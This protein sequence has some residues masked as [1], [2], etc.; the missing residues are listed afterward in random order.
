MAT[1]ADDIIIMTENEANLKIST[2]K[3]L[4]N[5]KEI[6]LTINE[7]KAKYLT[8]T[9]NICRIVYINIGVYKFERVVVWFQVFSCGH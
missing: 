3:L 8:I 9:R 7:D 5:G 6:E 4:E 2:R 1:Y